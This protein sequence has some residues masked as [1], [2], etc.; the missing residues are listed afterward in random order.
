MLIGG[1]AVGLLNFG[2]KVGQISAALFTL[3]A[4]VAMIYSLG[5]FHW[6]AGRIRRRGGVNA[7]GGATGG[8]LGLGGFDDRF[9]PT[10]LTIALAGAVIVNFVLRAVVGDSDHSKG[11]NHAQS[12]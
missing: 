4:M 12:Y 5:V 11:K 6:R 1:L 10:V 3:V 2:D 9:G 7:S 8:A